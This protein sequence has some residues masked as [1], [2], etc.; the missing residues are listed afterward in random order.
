MKNATNLQMSIFQP[1]VVGIAEHLLDFFA[2]ICL[3]LFIKVL[4]IKKRGNGKVII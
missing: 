2:N 3:M 1:Q 4:L